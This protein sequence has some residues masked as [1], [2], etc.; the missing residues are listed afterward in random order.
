[1]SDQ[2]LENLGGLIDAA[3]TIFSGMERRFQEA[4]QRALDFIEESKAKGGCNTV[5]VASYEVNRKTNEHLIADD[6]ADELAKRGYET[7]IV[8]EDNGTQHFVAVRVS[9]KK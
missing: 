2:R 5:Y 3:L 6:V 9:W 4:L 8:H 7:K 1:M